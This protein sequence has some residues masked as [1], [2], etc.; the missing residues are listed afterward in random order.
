MRISTFFLEETL[1]TK[2]V[3][4]IQYS[5]VAAIYGQQLI[6]VIESKTM[7]TE[8][9]S[10]DDIGQAAPVVRTQSRKRNSRAAQREQAR[11]DRFAAFYSNKE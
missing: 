2:F 11:K 7:Q 10:V 9:P 1:T 4:P 6:S 8:P 5:S 3:K